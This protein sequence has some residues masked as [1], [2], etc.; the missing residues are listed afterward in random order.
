M[1]P[2]WREILKQSCTKPLEFF[3]PQQWG[4]GFSTFADSKFK[5]LFF[6]LAQYPM[7]AKSF[8]TLLLQ[9]VFELVAW[10]FLVLCKSEN[11]SIHH[12]C[13]AEFVI[14]MGNSRIMYYNFFV[15]CLFY[16]Q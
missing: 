7:G 16:L 14:Y 13:I 11:K 2:Y 3:K 5:V 6:C 15:L 10:H 9:I 8:N 12:F 4:L 1:G